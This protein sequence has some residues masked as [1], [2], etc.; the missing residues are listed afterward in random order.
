MSPN[1]G[2]EM[3]VERGEDARVTGGEA[4]ALNGTVDRITW[5]LDRLGAGIDDLMG[6]G[7]LPERE[8]YALVGDLGFVARSAARLGA[9]VDPRGGG[10][11]GGDGELFVG[12]PLVHRPPGSE[13]EVEGTV[14][15]FDGRTFSFIDTEG[16]HRAGVDARAVALLG[17][18]EDEDGAVTDEAGAD[19]GSG[20]GPGAP[21]VGWGAAEPHLLALAGRFA[22]LREGGLLGRVEGHLAAIEAEVEALIDLGAFP[23]RRGGRPFLYGARALRQ[24]LAAF[25]AALPAEIRARGGADDP[26]G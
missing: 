10:R 5:L 14:T 4:E 9:A 18:P 2:D 16:K 12:L 19:P 1:E 15:G 25:G 26:G 13:A 8:R 17:P 24:D 23:G 7:R 20:P 22:A 21:A 11:P 6:R 3:R